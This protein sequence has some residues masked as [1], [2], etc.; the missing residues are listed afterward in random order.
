MTDNGCGIDPADKE[1][2][3]DPFFTR[4][5]TGRGLGLAVVL[6]LAKAG[7]GVVT[8]RSEPGQGSEFAVYLPL[9]GHEGGLR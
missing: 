9:V 2:L 3:F 6:G 4:K 5:F 7:G 1:Y 8:V